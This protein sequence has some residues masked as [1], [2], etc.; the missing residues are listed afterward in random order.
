MSSSKLVSF[1]GQQY[2]LSE[3]APYAL[4]F[5]KTVATAAHL[6]PESALVPD[7][8]LTDTDD[9]AVYGHIAIVQAMSPEAREIFNSAFAASHLPDAAAILKQLSPTTQPRAVTSAIHILSL[10]PDPKKHAY[11]RKFLRNA[12]ASKGL[13]TVL[14]DAFVRGLTWGEAF[15]TRTKASAPGYDAHCGLIIH[16]LFWCDPLGDDGKA[17]I[18]A[19]TRKQLAVALKKT[20]ARP[21]IK[22]LPM[23]DKVD[24]ERLRGL[25]QPLEGMPG[26]HYLDSTRDY[27]EGQV[28]M[29]GGN[30]AG[31]MCAEDG[32]SLCSRCK[33]VKYCGAACQ[34]WDWKHGHKAQCFQTAY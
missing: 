25:L 2:K 20:L 5:A 10:L 16:T 1:N 18:D 31:R 21:E 15:A 4:D 26:S 6:T 12:D 22:A 28:E 27:L 11:F 14:A 17:S 8:D 29:C 32:V 23:Q 9:K 19:E 7:T 33:S 13:G 34:N 24:V 30:A 3:L